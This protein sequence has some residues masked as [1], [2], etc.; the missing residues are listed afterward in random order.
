MFTDHKMNVK[1]HD[2]QN[3]FGMKLFIFMQT[4]TNLLAHNQDRSSEKW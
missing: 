2:L 1:T 3:S 4:G